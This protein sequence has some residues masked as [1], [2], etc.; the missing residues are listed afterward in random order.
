[1]LK[2]VFDDATKNRL[3]T[4]AK[5][6]LVLRCP[7]H[8]RYNPAHGRGAIVGRCPGCEAALEGY[9]AAMNLR[10]ALVRYSVETEKFETAKPRQKKQKAIAATA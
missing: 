9:E 10:S 3:K 8:T 1:M 4:V 5:S 2:M 6:K 7:K